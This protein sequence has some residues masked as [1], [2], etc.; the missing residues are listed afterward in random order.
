MTVRPRLAALISVHMCHVTD[1]KLHRANSAFG[2]QLCPVLKVLNPAGDTLQDMKSIRFITHVQ[3]V[4]IGSQ[5]RS[6]VNGQ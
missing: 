2:L 6:R 1:V 4:P 5:W 3:A